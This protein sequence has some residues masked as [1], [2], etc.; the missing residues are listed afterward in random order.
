MT[1]DNEKKDKKRKRSDTDEGHKSKRERRDK[2][3]EQ[4]GGTT[5][6]L[7]DSLEDKVSPATVSQVNGAVLARST[8]PVGALVPFAHPLA[9][10][11]GQKKIFKSLKKGTT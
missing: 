3:R 8:P 5:A 10:E 2:G 1:K 4:D 6:A 9:D 7:L 11:K